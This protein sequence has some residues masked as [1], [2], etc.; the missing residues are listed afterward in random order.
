MVAVVFEHAD[1]R[2][3]TV[4]IASGQSLMEGAIYGGVEGIDADCGGQLACAT[5]HIFVDAQ[6]REKLA[7]PSSDEADMLEFVAE[8]GEGSRLSCQI[9]LDPA[10]D[11][12]VVRI[13]AT[14]HA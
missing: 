10:L 11:G 3:E 7:P 13:P 1:G 2:R 14:Q 9:M 6:W 4:D 8:K 12:L 5:C